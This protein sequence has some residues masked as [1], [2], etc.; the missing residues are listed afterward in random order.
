VTDGSE[1][2]YPVYTGYKYRSMKMESPTNGMNSVWFIYNITPVE[3]HYNV[4]FQSWG[5]FL[6]RMC[7]IVGGIFAAVGLFETIL[8]TG[9]CLSGEK[10]TNKVEGKVEEK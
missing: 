4:F 1:P 8:S 10:E 6:V 7:A 2:Q 9:L 3:I 5:D